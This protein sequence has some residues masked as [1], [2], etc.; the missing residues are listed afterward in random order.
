[1]H[2]RYTASQRVC[3]QSKTRICQKRILIVVI[4][5]YIKVCFYKCTL[6]GGCDNI[7]AMDN[8]ISEAD[9]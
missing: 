6:R 5:F 4:P 7:A 8:D 3:R 9:A 2:V 1:M